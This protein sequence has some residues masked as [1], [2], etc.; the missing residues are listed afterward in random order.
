MALA[1]F[2]EP[3]TLMLLMVV[4]PTAIFRVVSFVLDQAQ[5]VGS[6]R[7]GV[8]LVRHRR[9]LLIASGPLLRAA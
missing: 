9:T 5:R 8:P 1:M 7:L 4:L 6:D 3:M 2:P